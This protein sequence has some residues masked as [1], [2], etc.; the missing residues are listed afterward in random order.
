MKE[1]AREFKAI[2]VAVALAELSW[3]SSG[4]AC[5]SSCSR[6]C[7][8]P[9]ARHELGPSA[10]DRDP[11]ISALT[12]LR[13]RPCRLSGA[14]ADVLPWH[15]GAARLHLGGAGD[16]GKTGSAYS[17]RPTR[18]AAERGVRPMIMTRNQ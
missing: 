15:G 14:H 5:S 6:N 1:K 4:I 7:R 3:S 11:V 9:R 18:S 8:L 10:C 13:A 16:N 12:G 17:G 2:L